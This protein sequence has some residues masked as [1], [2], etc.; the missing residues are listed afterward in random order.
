MSQR[1]TIVAQSSP[2][3]PHLRHEGDDS[4]REDVESESEGGDSSPEAIRALFEEDTYNPFLTHAFLESL[5]AAG[6]VGGRTG[7]QPCHVIV[8][9]ADGRIVA[10]APTYLKSHSQGEY[11]FDHAFA[12][13]Y[14]R[15][16]GAY[17]PKVQVAVPFTPVPGRRLLL[18]PSIMPALG[19]AALNKGLE[20]LRAGADASSIHLTF[21]L[22]REAEPLARMGWLERHGQQYHF[23]NPGYRDF[24]DFLGA[25]A[26]R[27]RKAIRRERRD[28]LAP[29]ITVERL[30]G[31]DLTE[32]H[33]D[34]FFAFY[35]NT[36]SRKW[37]RP[38]LNRRFFSL[39]GARMAK[40]VLLVMAKRNGQYIA[41]ALNL[42]GHSTLF[43]R[44]W[45]AIEEHPFLHFELCY[46]QAIDFA[47]AR[48][49]G[50]VEA[51]AQGDHKLSRGYRP[52]TT[53]SAHHFAHHGLKRAVADF[54]SHERDEMQRSIEELDM[55]TPF[56]KSEQTA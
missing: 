11:V 3:P 53:Y 52:V 29:G 34:A 28:A 47:I 38:Y 32:A 21:L 50:R 54:L 10:T 33:W 51:G 55:L 4:P 22:Q 36:G 48:R 56:R 18:G 35:M 12:D 45:G 43:G 6:C 19:I 26:A 25:L 17:Y 37:G 9:N 14:A 40:D 23:A 5:E 16:G 24:E 27:K 2:E 15:A 42:I 30:T 39:L 13:A 41:G 1:N 20:A 44:N 31:S 46:Y 7:W 49:L 8:E